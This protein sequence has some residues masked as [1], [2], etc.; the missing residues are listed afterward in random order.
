[1]TAS[2]DFSMHPA[3]FMKIG[4]SF[5]LAVIAGMILEPA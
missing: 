5:A 4:E 3:F 1:M 2:A